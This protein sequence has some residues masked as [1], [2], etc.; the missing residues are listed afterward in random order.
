MWITRR[1]D[2]LKSLSATVPAALVPRA[3]WPSLRADLDP[4]LL[5]PLAAVVLPSALGEEGVRRVVSDFRAWLDGYRPGA[6][7]SHGYGSGSMEIEYLPPDP[8]PRWQ[9][10]L[11]ELDALARGRGASGFGALA[12][13]G[14]L[15]L[16]RERLAEGAASALGAPAEADHVAVALMAFWFDSAEAANLA[17]GAVIEKE[18]CRSLASVGGR[19]D[20]LP[21]RK[22]P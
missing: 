14:R 8:T 19:P 9:A 10:Q 18:T 13:E 17:Y 12:P 6:E 2:F 1:R 22:L 16:V 20:A 5:S 7:R 15:A 21:V 4:A 3:W 11:E